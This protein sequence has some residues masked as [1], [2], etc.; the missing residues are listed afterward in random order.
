MDL[1]ALAT[2]LASGH[3]DTGAYNADDALAAGELNALNRPADVT[4]AD[5]LKFL[6]MDN[7]YKTD[8]GDDTQDRAILTRMRDVVAMATTPTEAAA[9]PWGSTSIGNITEI[10]QVKTHQL[11]NFIDLSAQGDLPV[12]LADSNFQ[13]YLAGAEASGCMSASQEAALLAL[14]NNLQSRSQDL[15]LGNVRTGD[16]TRARAL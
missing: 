1:A 15:E 9:N 2:E 12:D 10:Q 4:I 13:V 6:L 5:L 14:G 16:V 11:V 8:D 3:P 7:T